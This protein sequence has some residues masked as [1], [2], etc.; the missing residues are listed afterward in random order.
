MSS[1][2][3]AI[4]SVVGPIRIDAVLA[5]GGMGQVYRGF[6]LKLGR[7]V[8]LKTI[9]TDRLSALALARFQ[10]EAR[11]LSRLDDERI[12]RIFDFLET[13][14]GNFIVMELVAG[15]RLSVRL[16]AGIPRKEALSLAGQMAGALVVAHGRGIVHRDL[17]P[18]NIMVTPSIKVK[19]LDFGIAHVE[20]Q[21]ME[22]EELSASPSD[23][24]SGPPE[25]PREG[26][27]PAMVEPVKAVPEGDTELAPS[28]IAASGSG[29]SSSGRLTEEG[30]VV[31]TP[32]YM[33]PE[34]ISGEWPTPASDIYALG[35][36]LVEMI[37]GE[38]VRPNNLNWRQVLQVMDSGELK[39]IREKDRDLRRLLQAMLARN[40]DRRPTAREV[41]QALASI[42]SRP[43]R[44]RRRAFATATALLAILLTSYYLLSLQAAR[45][46]AEKERVRAQKVNDLLV[47]LF[48]QADPLSVEPKKNA[49]PSMRELIAHSSQQILDQP[50]LPP[51]DAALLLGTLGDIHHSLGLYEE[52]KRLLARAEE[53]LRQLPSEERVPLWWVSGRLAMVCHRLDH[54]AE[55]RRHFENALAL[56]AARQQQDQGE[57][58]LVMTSYGDM[59]SE[60]DDSF[61][62]ASIFLR[63]EELLRTMSGADPL[64]VATVKHR[65]G[66]FLLRAGRLLDARYRWQEA[67]EARARVLPENHPKISDLLNNLGYA[68]FKMGDMAEAEK[69]LERAVVADEASLGGT[70]PDLA[71]SLANLA[72]VAVALGDLSRAEHLARRALVIREQALGPH[73]LRASYSLATLARIAALRG[74]LEESRRLYQ[75]AL[76]IRQ[77]TLPAGHPAIGEVQQALAALPATA[78]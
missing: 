33:S 14:Q 26:E 43:Q 66:N 20:E 56:S 75:Q 1:P 15:E 3:M 31:G 21:A 60:L 54:F 65:H 41:E 51:E 47:G 2:G 16:A 9:R 34:Q 39:I 59:L 8:A 17:K 58:L 52:A 50:G 23:M 35:L 76:S 45:I 57:I 27:T 10:R 32:A 24:P 5:Q 71:Y 19:I 73:H 69:Y 68:A 53:H 63:A 61:A 42:E 37:S 22:P 78:Q 70:H 18:E 44:L 29:S 64:L 46:Q 11:L 77:T 4:G 13:P 38:K 72:D 55:A 74:Q 36:V 12:C 7:E 25:Q 30:S 28:P 48:R 49:N 67:L 40:P 6:H 62:A